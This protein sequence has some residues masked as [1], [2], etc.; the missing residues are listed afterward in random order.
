MSRREKA[1]QTRQRML[2]AAY[3]LFCEVGFR[4][5][6]M[7][8][9]AER[10]GVAV[11][12]LYFS[13]HTKDELVQA[14]HEYTV[15]GDDGV[16]P[17][18][19]AWYRAAVAEPDIAN[20]VAILVDGMTLILD[21]VAPM[22][23]AFQAVAGDPAG[24]VWRHGQELR[25]DGMGHLVDAFRAK[26]RL[27]RGLSR[28]HAADLFFVLLGPDLY[29]SLVI[30]RGW[31]KTHWSAWVQASLLRDVFDVPAPTASRSSR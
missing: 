15:L 21:R 23:P 25:Y 4:A 22:V 31:S 8:L 9:I 1:A 28:A 5:S 13:F 27:R 12:T 3:E 2:D 10:A 20:A 30:E 11:Q 17:P 29:R 18:Q 24:E 26:S 19:Q 6:T 16:P 7:E 14:V